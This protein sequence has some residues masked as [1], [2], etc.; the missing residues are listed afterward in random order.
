MLLKVNM[1]QAAMNIL[2]ATTKTRHSQI[3]KHICLLVEK[4]MGV[5]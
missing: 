1:P 2:C 3:N 4:G 5:I